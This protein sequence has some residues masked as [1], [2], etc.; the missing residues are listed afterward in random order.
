[1][2]GAGKSS[3]GATLHVTVMGPNLFSTHPLPEAGSITVGRDD[4]ADVRILDESA[5]RMHVRLHVEPGPQIFVE[6]LGTRNGTFVRDSRLVGAILM[7]EITRVGVHLKG[8]AK[9][10]VGCDRINVAI[11]IFST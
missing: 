4:S 1:M 8:W 9:S 10:R 3:A 7:G 5:S 6:D 2:A 11:T